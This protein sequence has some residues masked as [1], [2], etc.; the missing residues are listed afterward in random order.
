MNIKEKARAYDALQLVERFNELYPVGSS[1]MLR[2]IS[3]DSFP[4][5]P[6]EV[7]AEAFVSGGNQAYAFFEGIS[8]CF[9]IE[10]DFIDYPL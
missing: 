6:Y 1:V 5:K 9:S 3:M 10:P 2:K 7:K 4:Y 8:G